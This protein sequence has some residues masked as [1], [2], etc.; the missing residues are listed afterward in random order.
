[1]VDTPAIPRHDVS[2]SRKSAIRLDEVPRFAG[3][4]S[5][6]ITVELGGS[7]STLET[8]VDWFWRGEAFVMR[9]EVERKTQILPS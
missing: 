7:A 6:G 2:S 8:S 3:M 1:M 4:L 5:P 9:V